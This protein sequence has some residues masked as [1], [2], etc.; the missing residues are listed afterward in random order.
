MGTKSDGLIT[1]IGH[2]LPLGRLLHLARLV[3]QKQTSALAKVTNGPDSDKSIAD[4]RLPEHVASLAKPYFESIT[5]AGAFRR[6]SKPQVSDA[7][8]L[9]R[10]LRASG[11]RPRPDYGTK[12]RDKLAPPHVRS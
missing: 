5:A 9:S 3:F 7:D 1:A 8:N 12:K 6:G 4:E 10:L 11:K 2:K